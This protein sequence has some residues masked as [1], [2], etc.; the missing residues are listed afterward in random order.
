MKTITDTNA[1][2]QQV[3]QREFGGMD[4]VTTNNNNW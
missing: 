3:T 4:F 1:Y 2:G